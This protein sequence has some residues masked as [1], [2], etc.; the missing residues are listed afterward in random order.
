MPMPDPVPEFSRVVAV[1]AMTGDEV[2]ERIA[3]SPAECAA[4]AQRFDLVAIERLE[5][6]IRLSRLKHGAMVRT[7]GA[8]SAEVVQT[9]VVTLE[10]FAARVEESFGALF[11]REAAMPRH[12][13]ELD[14]DAELADEDWPEEMPG[15]RIDIGELTAQHLSLALDP[16]PRRP[17][18][19]FRDPG[20][21][22]PEPETVNPFGA[23]ARIVRNH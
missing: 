12:E 6:T 14:L 7:T 10:P 11:A 15:G 18:V 20:D 3:A 16:Y 23:L 9:C 17:G 19:E 22:P 2:V 1:E 21:P 13:L 5:A 4:L 8:L